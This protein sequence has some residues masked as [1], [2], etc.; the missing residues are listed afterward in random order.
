MIDNFSILLSHVLIA[1][2][3]YLLLERD[4]LDFEEPHKPDPDNEKFSARPTAS[5]KKH[6]NMNSQV[7]DN[8]MGRKKYMN[9]NNENARA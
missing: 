9:N 7:A 3:F 1:I 8:P 4:D 2:M 5:I 6:K